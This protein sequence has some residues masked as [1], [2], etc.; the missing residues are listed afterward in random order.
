MQNNISEIKKWSEIAQNMLGSIIL[1]LVVL[2]KILQNIDTGG[3][4][5]GN[6]N[7]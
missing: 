4:K 2:R 1:Q 5:K 6:A 7:S 3:S